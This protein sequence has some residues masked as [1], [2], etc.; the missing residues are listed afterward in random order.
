MTLHQVTSSAEP[1]QQVPG[2]GAD[3]RVRRRNIGGIDHGERRA[4][5]AR[6]YSASP[7]RKANLAASVRDATPSFSR[8]RP[9]CVVA[10]RWLMKRTFA[11][12]RLDL[13]SAISRRI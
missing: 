2:A 9:T 12:S 5:I 4:E 7:C 8:M 13:P 10:V 1:N 6:V 3:Q 11:I